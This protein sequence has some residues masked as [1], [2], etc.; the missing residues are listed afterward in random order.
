[1]AAAVFGAKAQPAR[2]AGAFACVMGLLIAGGGANRA[3]GET[4]YEIVPGESELRILVFRAGSLARLGHNH[5]VSTG[6]MAGTAVL[7]ASPAVSSLEMT[8]PVRSFVVDDPAALEEE[9][10]AFSGGRSE[11]DVEGTRRNMLGPDLLHA[12]EYDEVR[13]VSEGISG[14]FPQVTIQASIDIRGARHAVALPAFVALRDGGLV[15]SGL[16]EIAHS[17]LGL[18]PFEAAFGTLRVAEDMILRYR[19]VAREAPATVAEPQG[20]AADR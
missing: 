4:V 13:I 11:G 20:A 10:S 19:I 3:A 2:R 18:S 9:G 16:A 12:E 1:M 15:A 6:D 8:L 17:D 14:E 5:V 7:G